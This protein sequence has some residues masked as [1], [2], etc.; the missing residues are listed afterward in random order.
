MNHNPVLSLDTQSSVIQVRNVSKW[1]GA[2]QALNSIS[3]D[4]KPGERVV[5]CGPSGSGKLTLIRCINRLERHENGVIVVNGYELND[6][7][8]ILLPPEIILA[9]CSSTSIC[10]RISLRLKI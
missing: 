10:F 3:L 9:W 2:F 6:S 8:K 5:V 1:F 7:K 4:V